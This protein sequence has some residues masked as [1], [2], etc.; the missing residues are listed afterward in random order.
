MKV[1]TQTFK[2]QIKEQGR[3]LDSKITYTINNEKIELGN[4][5]LNFVTPHYQGN[6][7]KSVMKQLDLDSNIDIPLGTIINYKFGVRLYG[8]G[9]FEY[10]NFGNYIVYSSEKQEDLNSY[11]IICY[12]KMLNSMKNYESF[13]NEYPM[14]INNYIVKLC[15]KLG[16]IFKNKEDEYVNKNKIIENE[17]Y[18]DNKGNDIGYTFRDVF[19]E[20]A[21]VTAS[22]I[23]INEETDELEI[24]YINDTQ[25]TIDE[26]YFKD[27]NVNIGEKYGPINSIVLSRTAES[28]NIYLR[29]EESVKTNGL[30]ELKIKD[31]QIMNFNNR[32]EFLP[33]IFEKLNGLEYYIN[34][35]ELYGIVYYNI[36][37]KYNVKIK[38]STYSCVMLND[39]INITQ[40]LEEK[41]YCEK[42]NESETDYSKADKTDR[43]INQ[44]YLI[45]NK[46]EQR[47]EAVI[48][49]VDKQNEKISSLTQTVDKLETKISNVLVINDIVEGTHRLNIKNANGG[50][51][52]KF[53]IHGKY[54]LPIVS[55]MLIV[56]NELIVQEGKIRIIQDNNILN[57]YILPDMIL[58]SINNV[59]DE[60]VCEEGKCYIIRR[61][62]VNENGT[63]HELENEII[64]T[65]P[66]IKII[67]PEGNSII[68]MDNQSYMTCE[69]LVK[70]EYTDKFA[71]KIELSS[72]ITQTT[73]E[74]SLQVS[75]KVGEDEIISK[76]NQSAEKIEIDASK[77]SLKGKDIDLTSDNII[78]NSNNLK[79][80]QYGNMR[81]NNAFVEKSHFFINTKHF[82][83]GGLFIANYDENDNR[84]DSEYGLY[85]RFGFIISNGNERTGCQVGYLSLEKQ[86]N[87][88]E[89]ILQTSSISNNLQVKLSGS[90][91]MIDEQ[92]SSS[93][94]SFFIG[95]D[96]KNSIINENGIWAPS[97]NN[98]SLESKKKNII[99]DNGCL[100]EILNTDIVNFNWNFEDDTDKKHIG[101]IIPDLNGKYK[102]SQKVLNHD[103][104]AVDLY[105]MASMSWKAIQ[106]LYDIIELQKIKIEELEMKINGIT[107]SS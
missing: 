70:N 16:L 21:Q 18:L 3:E 50:I 27:V 35:F 23:V 47:I 61:L 46:Q 67:I 74:I 75:K 12:D 60:F 14:T 45:V 64:E 73:E 88:E 9:E 97:I 94:A 13:T 53:T 54:E 79:I 71:T 7:L 52:H 29:D 83:A 100:N 20:L 4:E 31:N 69:Y 81:M 56:S 26:E 5:E 76:I 42:P 40:G 57:E 84:L 28:D 59:Y 30:C 10:V 93:S 102:Y 43:R 98:T 58:N 62:K 78:I 36:C 77:I 91:Y 82:D 66:D 11:K 48:T 2:E 87:S 6:I 68:E 25:D 44:T 107:K 33:E 63:I 106:E 39:E 19:D 32:D 15:D 104:D 24:R 1:H 86:N 55:E 90:N 72:A 37:D 89:I 49:N 95:N 38:D 8:Q 65:L 34:D 17:L 80:D 51:L 22:T 103:E 96:T 41:I 92:V 85:Q 101:M 99:L 105:S